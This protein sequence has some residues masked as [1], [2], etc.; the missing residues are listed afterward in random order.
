MPHRSFLRVSLHPAVCCFT[1]RT[2]HPDS[3]ALLCID[4]CC[5]TWNKGSTWLT[6]GAIDSQLL[7]RQVTVG[8]RI[9]VLHFVYFDYF[10]LVLLLLRLLL[11]LSLDQI[12]NTFRS[13]AKQKQT[14]NV[15]R[16]PLVSFWFT[17]DHAWSVPHVSF[18][19]TN[20]VLDSYKNVVCH[21]PPPPV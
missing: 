9:P 17:T 8:N 5:I 13:A 10:W 2:T 20:L 3:S 16:I 21:H 19:L 6:K 7:P 1:P 12:F 4:Y 18:T 15:S 14:K 11:L